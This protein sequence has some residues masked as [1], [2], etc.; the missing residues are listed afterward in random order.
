ME[1]NIAVLFSSD[2]EGTPGQIALID[3][4]GLLYADVS[5]TSSSKK[6]YGAGP[7][8]GTE[9]VE[10]NGTTYTDGKTTVIDVN[11]KSYTFITAGSTSS[12][13]VNPKIE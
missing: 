11:G 12:L 8:V 9:T 2:Q 10:I 7:V 13:I 5:E 6:V 4:A 1:G 3:D